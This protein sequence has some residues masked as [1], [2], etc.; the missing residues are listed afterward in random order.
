M[1]GCARTV[2][3]ASLAVAAAVAAPAGAV[4]A[5]PPAIG[6]LWSSAVQSTTAHLEGNVNPAGLATGY[7]FDYIPRAAYEAN[8]AAAKE[9][10]AGALRAPPGSNGPIGSGSSPVGVLQFLSNL[11]PG[12]AYRYRLVAVNSAGAATSST[13]EFVTQPS[14]GG[15]LLADSRA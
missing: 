15:S 9:P 13:L 6:S 12:T 7:H 10:F 2:L 5:E 14:N 3:F 1:K 11:S 8:V 4:A